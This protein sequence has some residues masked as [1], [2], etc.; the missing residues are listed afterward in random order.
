MNEVQKLKEHRQRLGMTQEEIA[1]KLFCSRIT[2]TRWENDKQS[3]QPIFQ[4]HI[5]K[6]LRSLRAK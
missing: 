2:Y 4:T 1:K 6:L 5:K 3:P